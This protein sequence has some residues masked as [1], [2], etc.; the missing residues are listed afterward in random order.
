M[1]VGLE[2]DYTPPETTFALAVSVRVPLVLPVLRPIEALEFLGVEPES[3]P[4]YS[5][6]VAGGQASAGLA[7]FEGLGHFVVFESASAKE[8]Y[9][10]FLRDLATRLVPKVY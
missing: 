6:N 5:G 10:S 9:G 2:D 7:Q 8:R 4:P 1:T 3:L